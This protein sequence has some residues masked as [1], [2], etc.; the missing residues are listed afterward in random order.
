MT[1]AVVSGHCSQCR[2]VWTLEK[3]SGVCQWCN[4]LASCQSVRTKPRLIKS[5]STGNQRQADGNGNGYD[6]LEGEWLTYYKVA[7]RF[8]YKARP[9]DREDLLHDIILTIAQA[10]RN[11]GHKPFT[12]ATMYRIA[13]YTRTD[14]WRI[15]YK[16]INGLDCGS[17][18]QSQR[19]KCRKDWLY[20]ECPKAIKLASLDKPIADGE[21]SL[22]EQGELIADDKAIDLDAWLDARTFLLGFPQRLL[23]IADRINKGDALTNKDR[24]YLCYWRKR[25]QKS[26]LE[27]LTFQQ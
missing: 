5:R 10:E 1:T 25:E 3:V 18:N 20:P 12:E 9:E 2:K 26:L 27:N 22:T 19:Q 6:H 11:N 13:S 7:S 23:L 16:H 14:Y 21:G 4:R 15:H 24:Q 8:S 17:C